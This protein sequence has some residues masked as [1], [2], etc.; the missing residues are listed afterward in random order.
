M[1]N[2]GLQ[3]LIDEFGERIRFI[4]LDN[5]KKIYLNYERGVGGVSDRVIRVSDLVLKSFG[6]VDMFGYKRTEKHFGNG[7]TVEF[8][9]WNVTQFIQQVIIVEENSEMYNPDPLS[10]A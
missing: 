8:M 9:A 5:G 3:A 1:T 4:A 6:G 10:L 2:Q 7:P